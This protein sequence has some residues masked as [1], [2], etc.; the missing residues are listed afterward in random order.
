[1]S[2]YGDSISGY[3]ETWTFRY[4]YPDGEAPEDWVGSYGRLVGI[5][6]P[7][8]SQAIG[9]DLLGRASEI[10]RTII[11]FSGSS[12]LRR[13]TEASW[14]GKPLRERVY[15]PNGAAWNE[16]I[17]IEHDYDRAGRM[18]WIGSAV[19]GRRSCPS[20]D[21]LK[22]RRHEWHS[23]VPCGEDASPSASTTSCGRR[24]SPPQ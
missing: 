23:Q 8:G 24:S 14:S 22:A 17:R 4:D 10:D 11:G 7:D 2:R 5:D 9:Y 16:R 18:R 1:M 20:M 12:T 19:E 6:G 3:D 13:R 15:Q 21:S